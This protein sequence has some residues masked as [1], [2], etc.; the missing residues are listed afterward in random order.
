MD[1]LYGLKILA[2]DYFV[3]SQCTR[4]TDRRTDRT[5][6]DGKTVRCIRSRAVKSEWWLCNIS[7]WQRTR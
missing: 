2:V 7:R 4:L 3:L 1:L 6:G 5:K